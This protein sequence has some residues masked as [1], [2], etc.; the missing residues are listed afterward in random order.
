MTKSS[1]PPLAD[2]FIYSLA[3]APK[4]P[5]ILNG[6]RQKEFSEPVDP[7][8]SKAPHFS[9]SRVFLGFSSAAVAPTTFATIHSNS[10]Y[11]D[12]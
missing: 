9:L 10:S 2:L 6:S 1:F 3:V 7:L 4:D 12:S 8:D 11:K 5:D